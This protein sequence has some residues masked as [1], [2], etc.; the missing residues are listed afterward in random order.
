MVGGGSTGSIVAARLAQAKWKVLLLEAGGATQAQLGGTEVERGWK[1]L[2]DAENTEAANSPAASAPSPLPLPTVFDVPLEWH[3]VL[4]SPSV[5][6]R[7]EWELPSS[8]AHPRPSIA[9]GLGGCSIHNAMVYVRGVDQDFEDSTAENIWPREWSWKRVLPYYQRTV[10][11][12]D[13][14]LAETPQHAPARLAPIEIGGAQRGG[15]VA[16][17]SLHPDDVDSFSTRVLQAW[18]TTDEEAS[19]DDADSPLTLPRL[20]DMNDPARREGAALYQFLIDAGRR[21]TAAQALYGAQIQQTNT[22]D[23]GAA[24]L[25]STLHVRTNVQATRIVFE[26]DQQEGSASAPGSSGPRAVGVECVVFRDGSYATT[27]D[28]GEA[29]AERGA[30]D[31]D[32]DSES[33][34]RIPKGASPSPPHSAP[35][36]VRARH[37]VIVSAGA[38]N[39]PK[40]L[41]LSGVGPEAELSSA[42]IPV[43]SPLRGVGENLMDGAKIVVQF[44]AAKSLRF[45]PCMFEQ[46]SK[47]AKGTG[48]NA[49]EAAEMHQKRCERERAKWI[50]GQIAAAAAATAGSASDS[51]PALPAPRSFGEFGTPGFSVGA[52]LRSSARHALPNI[53]LTVFP[54][55]VARRNWRGA[56]DSGALNA[57]LLAGAELGDG[58]GQGVVSIEVILNSPKS[59]GSVKLQPRKEQQSE[60]EKE[61]AKGKS[62]AATTSTQG[63]E[64]KQAQSARIRHALQPPHVHVGSF[65]AESDVSDMLDALR[66]VRRLMAA[67]SL[68]SQVGPEL[69]P[70]RD[71]NEEQLRDYI[72]CGPKAFRPKGVKCAGAQR[73]VGHLA[74]TARISS[75]SVASNDDNEVPVGIRT[76]PAARD[77]G[78]VVDPALRVHGVRALRVADASVMPRLPGG[79]THA[80]CIMIGERAADFILEAHPSPAVRSA[81][82]VSSSP[83]PTTEGRATRRSTSRFNAVSNPFIRSM[84]CPE[85]RGICRIPHSAATATAAEAAS[86]ADAESLYVL[87]AHTSKPDPGDASSHDV[88]SPDDFPVRSERIQ[89]ARASASG[90]ADAGDDSTVVVARHHRHHDDAMSASGMLL[91]V[92]GCVTML[93]LYLLMRHVRTAVNGGDVEAA[94][95]L[96]KPSP[97]KLQTNGRV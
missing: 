81:G 69:V 54:F 87:D 36:I 88:G 11:Q 67:P 68:R 82:G 17:S 83:A 79:N 97:S 75:R 39:T 89:H 28:S 63:G 71:L 22:A 77:D 57:T 21:D 40:L 78:S 32:G 53:Q 50:E 30:D 23:G 72:R 96:L 48:S 38:I 64:S 18:T 33:D 24:A 47:H 19:G 5:S 7:F 49:T 85:P 16:L 37:E 2:M 86:V 14:T 20:D 91:I 93:L 51:A 84:Q 6:R 65:D 62:R 1:A 80:T 73:M 34:D 90:S 31:D 15:E 55:D 10:Q 3:T 42:S 95:P 59:R 12:R 74:G 27:K 92:L 43:V 41:L 58:D 76:D 60:K 13:A 56:L 8:P 26:H 66:L 25:E 44:R 94:E 46:Q 45:R 4:A 35:F 52:F 61:E 9:R 29:G 70:G